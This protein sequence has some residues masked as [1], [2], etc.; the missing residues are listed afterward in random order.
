MISLFGTDLFDIFGRYLIVN[1]KAVIIIESV[2][3]NEVALHAVNNFYSCLGGSI[4]SLGESLH[5]SVIGNCNSL[6]TPCYR[7]AD[8]LLCAR[9]T[10]H[11]RHICMQVQLHSL[12]GSVILL[13]DFFNF[14][15]GSCIDEIG[16]H[17]GVHIY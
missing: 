2:I 1:T 11:C 10:V 13:L 5:N 9:H 7:T 16:V 14:S 8:K 17:I 4:A 6:V 3:V 15:D 12:F